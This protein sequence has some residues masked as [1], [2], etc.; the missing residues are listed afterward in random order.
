MVCSLSVFHSRA[1]LIMALATDNFQ[2]NQWQKYRQRD[3]FVSLC[4]HRYTCVHLLLLLHLYIH[5]K[6]RITMVTTLSSQAALASVMTTTSVSTS[7]DRLA[8]WDFSWRHQL[9]ETCHVNGFAGCRHPRTVFWYMYFAMWCMRMHLPLYLDTFI[10]CPL[11]Y[12]YM[13]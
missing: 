6:P 5:W 12:L 1:C 9:W 3:I 10:L 7:N 13:Y 8:S 11:L 4:A 2:C